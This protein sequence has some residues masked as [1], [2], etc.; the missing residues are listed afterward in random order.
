MSIRLP[1]VLLVGFLTAFTSKTYPTTMPI[2]QIL[3]LFTFISPLPLLWL[4]LGNG[5]TSA[6][7][8]SIFAFILV[9]LGKAFGSPVDVFSFLCKIA[10]TLALV[11]YA[12]L[13]RQTESGTEWYPAGNILVYLTGISAV[14]VLMYLALGLIPTVSE[15]NIRQFAAQVGNSNDQIDQ[16]YQL[17][18]KLVNFLPGIIT[19]NDF[20]LV[21][22]N[23]IFAQRILVR[24]K[25]NI[26][27][28][29]TVIPLHLPDY[30][31]WVA[32][33]FAGL[34]AVTLTFNT[35]G[36]YSTNL[37]IVISAAYFIVG[38]S[39]V[40]EINKLYNLNTISLV[41]F[42]VVMVLFVWLTVVVALMGLLEPW[43]RTYWKSV[44]KP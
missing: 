35:G 28:Q 41:V 25:E 1:Y 43:L 37:L 14:S 34:V 38:L 17:V 31:I 5:F 15:E 21:L 27:P 18:L 40:H 11:R 20:F 2:W 8:A 22:L 16:I 19:L 26:R 32:A 29:G 7:I 10:L 30:F 44:R 23:T 6:A 42:Y 33:G 24:Q 39:L 13:S 12:L 36:A 4:G 9:I 3:S